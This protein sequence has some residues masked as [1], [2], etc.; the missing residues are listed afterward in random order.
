MSACWS[1]GASN[2]AFSVCQRLR[3]TAHRRAARRSCSSCSYGWF[4][5]ELLIG[6][7]LTSEL[8]NETGKF[9]PFTPRKRNA[10]DSFLPFVVTSSP[11]QRHRHAPPPRTDETMLRRQIAL[12]RHAI[13]PELIVAIRCSQHLPIS[14]A[15]ARIKNRSLFFRIRTFC[16]ARALWQRCFAPRQPL[17]HKPPTNARCAGESGCLSLGNLAQASW[18]AQY[19]R[20]PKSV[21][22]W[23]VP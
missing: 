6:R 14:L 15:N 4:F 8:Q 3:S 2:L 20:T 7:P 17:Y 1:Y 21:L 5:D 12:E 19:R 13:K 23:F 10:L 22:F 9:L 16:P 18:V 11:R